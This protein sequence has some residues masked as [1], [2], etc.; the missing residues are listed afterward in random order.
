MI[1][2][3][4]SAKFPAK[5]ILKGYTAYFPIFLIFSPYPRKQCSLNIY[6]RGIRSKQKPDKKMKTK[7]TLLKYSALSVGAIGAAT[8][9]HASTDY[10][11]AIWNPPSGCTKYYTAG[12]GHKFHVCHDMEGY[13]QAGIS[14]LRNCSVSSSVHYA[15]NS[16][17]DT[18]TD[19]PEG[20]ITQMVL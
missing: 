5:F 7:N 11:P 4:P 20:E 16:K 10:G 15:V 6:F 18:S 3:L 17:H 8:I 9:V 2:G 1:L 19:A 12:Y 14:T 13:Y